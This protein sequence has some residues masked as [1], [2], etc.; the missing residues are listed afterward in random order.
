MF[1]TVII[2]FSFSQYTHTWPR[3]NDSLKP[4]SIGSRHHS[5][6]RIITAVVHLSPFFFRFLTVFFFFVLLKLNFINPYR[7][8]PSHHSRLSIRHSF[9]HRSR[10]GRRMCV[11]AIIIIIYRISGRGGAWWGK[12]KQFLE[13]FKS[14][15]Y[16]AKTSFF[17][18]RYIGGK[19]FGCV[20]RRSGVNFPFLPPPQPRSL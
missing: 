2:I 10:P 8:P 1:R 17:L 11:W 6:Q 16:K 18:S 4:I 15:L 5:R 14:F 19:T 7:K 12:W 13:A 9:Y 20:V 3:D